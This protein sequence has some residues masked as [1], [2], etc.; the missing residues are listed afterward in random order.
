MPNTP[1]QTPAKTSC[2]TPGTG[3]TLSCLTCSGPFRRAGWKPGRW[4]AAHPSLNCSHISTMS[5]LFSSL[6]TPRFARELPSSKSGRSSSD[7][8][9]IAQMLNEERQ[10]RYGRRLKSTVEEGRDMQ[11]PLRSSD[12]PAS[13]HALARGLPPR[14]D[15][16]GPQVGGLPIADEKAGPLTWGVW[17]R[18]SRAAPE[19]L[20]TFFRLRFR[21]IDRVF[22]SPFMRSRVALAA[23]IPSR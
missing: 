14:S 22:I 6:R 21:R 19:S 15:Q 3:T 11:R 12:P 2:W 16:A 10:R 9:R 20:I 7:P 23:R 17:M 5:G 13:A 1:D 4:K 18:K 8:G